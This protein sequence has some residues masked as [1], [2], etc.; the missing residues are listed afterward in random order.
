MERGFS[1][2]ELSIVLVILGLL[3]G[4]IL[5]GQSLIAAA[6]LRTIST[7]ING[8]N[9]SVLTFIDNYRALP[10]DMSNAT[11]FWGEAP[12][13]PDAS[14][15]G[16]ETCNGNGDA[17]L[18]NPLI[19]SQ[20]GEYFTFW[21]HLGNANLIAGSYTG[22]AGANYRQEISPGVNVPKSKFGKNAGF[23][24]RYWNHIPES[25]KQGRFNIIILGSKFGTN[26][27]GD[28][29]VLTPVQMYGVD[30][31]FDDGVP[32]TGKIFTYRQT[33]RP[34]CASSDSASTAEYLLQGEA[35]GCTFVIQFGY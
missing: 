8:I 4:G 19:A 16:I 11:R 28:Q 3:T 18:Q 7:Q 33:T 6:E 29:P 17:I 14:G 31:K 26:Y 12:S 13:C 20:F 5:A 2:V 32:G 9:T 21:Q 25:L 34:Q 10:G 23:S 35:A 22:V 15:N 1:L 30:K 24:V 27:D